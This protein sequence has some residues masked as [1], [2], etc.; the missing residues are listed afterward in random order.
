MLLPICTLLFALA[1]ASMGTYSAE[2]LRYLETFGYL[3]KPSG[4]A[5]MLSETV[6]E[7]AIREL[8]LYG[9]IPVT[10]KLDAE[11][12]ELMS[13]KRC[14][15]P[16]RQMKRHRGRHRKRYALM[17]TRW[18]KKILTYSGTGEVKKSECMYSKTDDASVGREIIAS[19]AR[20][21]ITEV[22]KPILE[23]RKPVLELRK[24]IRHDRAK[25]A[26]SEVSLRSIMMHEIGHSLG[27][28]H[29]Q[30]QDSIM[31]SF[32]Q[33]DLPP[34]LSYDDIV[35]IQS[36]YGRGHASAPE[37]PKIPPKTTPTY[38]APLPSPSPRPPPQQPHTPTDVSNDETIAP[39]PCTS[40]IDA[41]T[42]IRG[43]V[44]AFKGDWFW[45]IHHD[46]HLS[47]GPRRVS[48][49]WESLPSPIDA[50]VE[51]DDKIIFFIG[52]NV[53][54][55]N[56]HK[57]EAVK[58]LTAIGLPEY[59][60]HI[61]LVYSWNYWTEKPIYIWTDDEFWRVDKKSGKVEIGYPRKIATTWHYVPAEAS[62]ALT[63]NDDL[64]F[65]AGTD[66]FK[67]HSINMSATAAQPSTQ[68]W[69]HCPTAMRI[70]SDTVRSVPLN[71]TYLL[72]FIIP[73][74]LAK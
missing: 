57:K 9:Q 41:I 51:D 18:H 40:D 16:D 44:F 30:Q 72:L 3:P 8:Q 1:P 53:Y 27:L 31:Y 47:E 38:Q 66:V 11:T 13:R 46:G 33:Y 10:G 64:Y 63:F 14:G 2:T 74:M 26:I 54:V 68:L 22:R 6:V 24:P 60:D 32:Y 61:R 55:Y 50:V 35:A 71:F 62:A 65:F 23:L 29:S 39:D 37:R 56:G 7:E 34:Q 15:L 42:E 19:T 73:F 59:V 25:K 52:K 70:S 28:S 5:A 49:F 69:R 45:R 48:S 4:A 36:I 21:S 17:G 67:F 58:P 43:E 12:R 20:E